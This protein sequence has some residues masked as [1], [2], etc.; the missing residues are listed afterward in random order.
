M[1]ELELRVKKANQ[2]LGI[3]EVDTFFVYFLLENGS[4]QVWLQNP[5]LEKAFPTGTERK[6]LQW[7]QT[8]YSNDFSGHG[9]LGR[10]PDIRI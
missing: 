1:H 10:Q 9:K 7:L 8:V 2:E 3:R 5:W 4:C 6:Y